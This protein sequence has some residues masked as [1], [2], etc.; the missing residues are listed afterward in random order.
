MKN[1]VTFTL[2]SDGDKIGEGTKIKS[3][4]ILN[5]ANRIPRATILLLDGDPSKQ[6]FSLS[7]KDFFKPGRKIEIDLGFESK[8]ENVFK[9]IITR[10]S[11]KIRKSGESFL[12]ITC[13][14]PVAGLA[15][16]KTNR[17][18]YNLSDKDA[19]TQILDEAAIKYEIPGISALK[20]T[21][22]VQYDSSSW[23]FIL[24]RAD[25]HGAISVFDTEK[26]SIVKPSVKEKETI[27][28]EYGSTVL[29]MEAE[30][31]A[32]TQFPSVES[33]SWSPG[34]Q[35]IIE[36]EGDQ[37]FKNEIGNITSKELSKVLNSK[38]L[39]L[40][41]TGNLPEDEL[42]T[43][44]KAKAAK[45]ELSKIQG[46]VTIIGQSGI[47]PGKVIML[48]GFGDRFS[49]KAFVTG[50]R[51]EI[52]LGNWTTDI[53][54][55]LPSTWFAENENFNAL[56]AAGM[57]PAVSGLQIGVVTQLEG[58][59]DKEFRLR[60]RIP[61][62]SKDDE[63]IWAQMSKIYAGGDYGF[64]FYP[65]I[66]DEVLIG[67]LNDDPRKPVVLGVLHSSAKSSPL[68]LKDD[69]HEKGIVSRNDLRMIWND[70]K[71]FISLTTPAGNEITLNESTKCIT[72]KDMHDNKIIMNNQ[73]ITIETAKD[74]KLKA[75]KDIQLQGL[76]ISSKASGKFSAEGNGGAEVR[77]SSIAVLKGSLVQIN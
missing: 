54:F 28:C 61:I 71:K 11:I 27:N 67:F 63:G 20:H 36:E 30:M 37:E 76:N 9:G 62:V 50:V 64:C 4:V 24:S 43:W 31:D 77:T 13:K 74:L 69:N 5:E 29:R 7:N 21:Q 14:H 46:N 48:T 44:A 58:D 32:E 49:G 66:G 59:P 51:H 8:E 57:L 42:S 55:G 75:G 33:R 38:P 10:S 6:D 3:I 73:G 72:I 26:L 52:S 23:D 12:E 41:H 19:I 1:V 35:D 18:F 16:Y 65:E 47:F 15:T 70:D 17:S 45:N 40:H 39:P 56:P 53:Q 25:A 22:L 34:T 2:R 68:P 60:V